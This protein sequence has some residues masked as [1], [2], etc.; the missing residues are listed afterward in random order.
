MPDLCMWTWRTADDDDRA[1]LVVTCGSLVVEDDLGSL[2]NT[3]SRAVTLFSGNVTG[4]ATV[5]LSGA[6]KGRRRQ[7]GVGGWVV[8]GE[9]GSLRS[10]KKNKSTMSIK[11]QSSNKH[12]TTTSY[13]SFHAYFT[14][15]L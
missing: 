5:L 13:S 9:S 14:F 1:G 10:E 12:L 11:Q 6:R 3:S 15:R 7:E 4:A 8:G 2:G